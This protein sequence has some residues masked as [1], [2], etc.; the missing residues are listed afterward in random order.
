M[1]VV[2]DNLRKRERYYYSGTSYYNAVPLS[3]M[4]CGQ[5]AYEL[6]RDDA[7]VT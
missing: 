1:I 6:Y 3:S 5:K 4:A 7:F 2:I